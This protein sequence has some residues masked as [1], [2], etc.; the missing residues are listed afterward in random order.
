LSET[1]HHFWPLLYKSDKSVCQTNIHLLT[2]PVIKRTVEEISAPSE[3]TPKTK[4]LTS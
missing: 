2:M 4:L 3:I 1:G